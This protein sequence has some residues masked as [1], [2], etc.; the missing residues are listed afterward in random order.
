MFPILLAKALITWTPLT[1]YIAAALAHMVVIV[2][3]FKLLQ[4][5]PE[6][7]SILGGLICAGA[8]AAIAYFTRDEGL[9][10]LLITAAAIFGG[11]IAL[12]AGDAL[13]S[14]LI[15]GLCIGVYIGL[16]SFVVPR[17][18]LSYEGVGGFA[19]AYKLGLQD[20]ALA[21]EDSLYQHT[22]GAKKTPPPAGADRR[23]NT[24]RR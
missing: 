4:I 12:S 5:D 6:H 7:N 13:K 11:L 3:G 16:G 22:D 15:A 8:I 1:Y 2:V 23:P 21:S 9:V 20:E 24:R 14:L 19:K 18:P 10:G 17:T